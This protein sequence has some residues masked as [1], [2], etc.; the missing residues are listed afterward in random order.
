M[1]KLTCTNC[2]NALTATPEQARQSVACP[3]C[4]DRV[5]VPASEWQPAESR[6]RAARRAE[7]TCSNDAEPGSGPGHVG[8]FPSDSDIV[9]ALCGDVA[10]L[11]GLVF[12]ASISRAKWCSNRDDL[13]VFLELRFQ[14]GGNCRGKFRPQPSCRP[15]PVADSDSRRFCKTTLCQGEGQKNL[16]HWE[17]LGKPLEN[18]SVFVEIR[19]VADR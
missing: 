17:T 4:N 13:V 5:M 8:C 14:L 9:W 3:K 12:L 1:L 16:R 15:W 18:C 2:T 7:P 10:M 11:L 6:F 19:K